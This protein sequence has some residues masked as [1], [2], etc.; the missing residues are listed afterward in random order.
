VVT[1]HAVTFGGLLLLGGRAGDIFGRRRMFTSGILVFS[2]ASLF[3]GLAT[4]EG[5]L[6][7]A[8]RSRA[9]APQWPLRRRCP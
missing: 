7:A 9:S 1:G 5:W 3:G 8:R 4:S 6:I 2:L